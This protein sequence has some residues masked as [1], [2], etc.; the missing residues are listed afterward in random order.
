[1][2]FSKFTDSLISGLG[3]GLK[4]GLA[5]GLATG[6]ETGLATGLATGLETGLGTGLPLPP[7]CSSAWIPWFA[8]H[9]IRTRT[10][11]RA[12]FRPNCK[13]CSRCFEWV[14]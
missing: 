12:V 13:F 11:S 9:T 5:T 7:Y 8:L 6:L 10:P 4:T 3:T 2:G 14:F 1:M